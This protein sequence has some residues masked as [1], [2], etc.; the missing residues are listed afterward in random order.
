MRHPVSLRTADGSADETLIRVVAL[1]AVAW[2]GVYLGWR[3]I[4]TW[5]HTEPALFLLLFA[6]ELFGWLMLASFCFLSW[7]IP[8]S[9]ARPR[10][11]SHTAWTS[12]SAP[13]TRA[14]TYSK[15]PCSGVPAS[16][17]HT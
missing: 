9:H 10:S 5:E 2:G 15:P 4:D 8:K 6:C 12:S 7:R 17:T 16:P 13:T 1:L 11:T 14:S 3:V